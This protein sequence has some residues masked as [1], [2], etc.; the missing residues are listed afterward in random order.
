M[1]IKYD[2]H[3]EHWESLKNSNQKKI[4][5]WLKDDTLD[6]WRHFRKIEN[7]KPL[8][9]HSPN[10]RWLTVGDGRFGTDAHNLKKIGA[11]KVLGWKPEKN[12]L[13]KIILDTLAWEKKLLE[14]TK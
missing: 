5:T 2:N 1:K 13:E 7:L 4:L 14:E 3:G 12:D 6:F 9:D 8:I 11:K 10:A